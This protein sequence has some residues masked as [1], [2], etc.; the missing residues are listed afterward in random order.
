MNRENWPAVLLFIIFPIAIFTIGSLNKS[1]FDS[2]GVLFMAI[3]SV[4]GI[5]AAIAALIEKS[6]VSAAF[7]G[8]ITFY[9]LIPVT[10]DSF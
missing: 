7:Y 10:I 3:L 8:F 6:F 1:L 9:W 4:F 2:V 5:V